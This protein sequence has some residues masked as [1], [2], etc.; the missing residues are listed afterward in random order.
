MNALGT[1]V[2]EHYHQRCGR[3]GGS[4]ILKETASRYRTI[5]RRAYRTN[6]W[7]SLVPARARV[8]VRTLR[9]RFPF[10]Y[11]PSAEGPRSSAHPP[12]QVPVRVR[13]LR[14]S[15]RVR[16][17]DGVAFGQN[18]SRKGSASTPFPPVPTLLHHDLSLGWRR[19]TLEAGGRT[20]VC[21][22]EGRRVSMACRPWY[23]TYS[24]YNQVPTGERSG[25]AMNQD[26]DASD[27]SFSA[28]ALL[29]RVAPRIDRV[30]HPAM[31]DHSGSA[32]LAKRARSSL[33]PIARE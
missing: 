20:V 29:R 11:A 12:P 10:G 7:Q 21:S 19:R 32:G 8:R 26:T 16:L 31:L 30:P 15:L 5:R 25:K 27:R 3:H 4:T 33:S 23:R 6:W 24:A 17:L 1:V 2:H 13:S 28:P 18:H 22:P 9:R 14:R